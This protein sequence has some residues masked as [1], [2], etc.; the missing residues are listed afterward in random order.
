MRSC[1]TFVDL[2]FVGN[3]FSRVGQRRTHHVQCCLDVLWQTL[4]G[5][6]CFL[7]YNRR[8]ESCGYELM[9][10]IPNTFMPYFYDIVFLGFEKKVMKYMNNDLT[11][12]ITRK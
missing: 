6:Q 4:N 1:G 11:R 8:V 3:I 9:I 5:I 7:H 10:V 12:A 2:K